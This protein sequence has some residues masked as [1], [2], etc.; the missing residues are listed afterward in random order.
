MTNE[1]TTGAMYSTA[2]PS[3]QRTYYEALL[4]ETLRTKSIL[5]PYTIMKEDHA[6]RNTGIV[7]YT[8]VFDTD[9]NY[10]ALAETDIWMRGAHLDSRS[11]QISLEIH[12]DTLKFSD[13]S[14][15]VQYINQGNLKGLVRDKIGQNMRDTLDILARNAFLSV[16]NNYKRFGGSTSRANRAAITAGDVF[17]P[18]QA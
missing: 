5:M 12:G 1:L 18:D 6:A 10:N 17:D 7:S 4:L 13:Y 15:V 16:D 3:W 2:I 14:E 8:E 11:L 9:P